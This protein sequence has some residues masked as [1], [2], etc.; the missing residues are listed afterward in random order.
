[1]LALPILILIIAI[2]VYSQPTS[3]INYKNNPEFIEAAEQYVLLNLVDELNG[4][5]E[6]TKTVQGR[7]WLRSWNDQR[8]AIMSFVLLRYPNSK[9]IIWHSDWQERL[10]QFCELQAKSVKTIVDN[11]YDKRRVPSPWPKVTYDVVTK[12]AIL[13]YDNLYNIFKDDNERKIA[14]P[15]RPTED[16]VLEILRFHRPIYDSERESIKK[17]VQDM[18]NFYGRII[19]KSG[20]KTY[21]IVNNE[22]IRKLHIIRYK[23][24]L[25]SL[26][27][28]R[29]SDVDYQ[30]VLFRV[31]RIVAE[32]DVWAKFDVHLETD[33]TN[34][35]LDLRVPNYYRFLDNDEA[36]HRYLNFE[37]E[38]YDGNTFIGHENRYDDPT[39]RG[40]DFEET[41][42]TIVTFERHKPLRD[43]ADDISDYGVLT[44]QFNHFEL[45]H[46]PIVDY[47]L[48][49]YKAYTFWFNIDNFRSSLWIAVTDSN[50]NEE[51]YYAIRPKNIATD[52]KATI[53]KEI[54]RVFASVKDRVAA[55]IPTFYSMYETNVRCANQIKIDIMTI[56][57]K[58]TIRNRISSQALLANRMA[59]HSNLL[60]YLNMLP[61]LTQNQQQSQTSLVHQH[62]QHYQHEKRSTII[63]DK[64][65]EDLLSS[66]RDLFNPNQNPLILEDNDVSNIYKLY[67]KPEDKKKDDV[68]VGIDSN[69]ERKVTQE[70]APS[71]NTLHESQI[72]VNQH[73]DDFLDNFYNLFN[74]NDNSWRQL[75]YQLQTKNSYDSVPGT[76][77]LNNYHSQL[78]TGADGERFDLK[79]FD[80]GGKPNNQALTKRFRHN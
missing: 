2:N 62:H 15:L 1:M 48:E 46:L 42:D 79:R 34:D 75:D 43:L 12:R 21:Y 18:D 55:R 30:A 3:T 41:A 77:G 10:Q 4:A 22:K 37:D 47:Y 16:Q 23:L 25:H 76:S 8:T 49:R 24:L 78:G 57:K 60:N 26:L 71:D 53:I 33:I 19:D 5:K 80:H 36:Y 63:D 27:H 29:M 35:Y 68:V 39:K 7:K 9:V 54:D 31:E 50:V 38:F 67:V 73:Q 28:K 51:I 40:F 32:L 59:R 56:K 58:K 64:I 45:K 74:P 44:K 52:D 14:D 17:M 72:N 13:S 6:L 66:A 65:D 61:T 20:K 11:F 70:I 69:N